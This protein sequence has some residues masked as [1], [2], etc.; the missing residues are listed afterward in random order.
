MT[1]KSLDLLT[2]CSQKEGMQIKY[3]IVKISTVPIMA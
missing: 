3:S 1:Y 2:K